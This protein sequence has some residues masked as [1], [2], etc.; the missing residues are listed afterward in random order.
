MVASLL[1]EIAEKESAVLVYPP[2]PAVQQ[3]A[4]SLRVDSAP[5]ALADSGFLPGWLAPARAI[6]LFTLFKRARVVH[7][8]FHTPFSCIPAIVLARLAHAHR[9]IAT[10]HYIA[11]LAFLRH[12]RLSWP[13][14]MA[15]EARIAFAVALKRWSLRLVDDVVTLSEG[16]RS[17]F[18]STM[19]RRGSPRVHLIPNGIDPARFAAVSHGGLRHPLHPGAGCLLVTT[20]A[21]L[22]NQ[23]GHVF[24]IRAIPAVLRKN[25]N[26]RFLFVGEGHLRAELESLAESLSLA[27]AVTFAGER[28]DIAEILAGSDLFVLQ[29]LF[30]G[31]PVS[32][33]EA[34]AAGVAVVATDVGGT[35][36]VVVPEETGLLVRPQDPAALSDA[37][38][39]LL[40]DAARR[41]RLGRGGRQRVEREFS[42]AAMGERYL[43]LFREGPAGQ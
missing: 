9:I 15:R 40:S 5:L 11:Q 33:L 3:W 41:E 25:P 28:P 24:L 37:I 38:I 27:R 42:A 4:R 30:E 32:V 23:K 19:G 29:S 7:F 12:R 39:Y 2:A 6:R 1:N 22:N 43:A 20:V 13:L 14:A 31:M 17:I 8:H 18:E 10:E 21:G 34:M 16:N 26:A 35:R 36:D